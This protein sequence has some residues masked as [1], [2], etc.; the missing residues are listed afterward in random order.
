VIEFDSVR[1]ADGTHHGTPPF[2][3]SESLVEHRAGQKLQLRRIVDALQQALAGAGSSVELLAAA[4]GRI[5]ALPDAEPDQ[6][7]AAQVAMRNLKTAARADLAR[8]AQQHA[9][10]ADAGA[11]GAG[12]RAVLARYEAWLARLSPP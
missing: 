1:W 2:P 12:L 4:T 9:T 8:L 7:Q 3:Q 11:V 6:L 5:D 10:P